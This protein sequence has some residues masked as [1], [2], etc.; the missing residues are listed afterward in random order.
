M[1]LIE[2]EGTS[3]WRTMGKPFKLTKDYVR[4]GTVS[5]LPLYRMQTKKYA[6]YHAVDNEGLHRYMAYFQRITLEGLEG[7]AQVAVQRDPKIK[8]KDLPVKVVYLHALPDLQIIFSDQKQTESGQWLWENKII[9]ACLATQKFV[10]TYDAATSALC[11][12][13]RHKHYA[14]DLWSERPGNENRIVVSNRRIDL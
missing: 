14:V 3:K 6:M 12:V 2:K 9:P 8:R 10:Y 13:T 7:W 1:R 11:R 5:K 4:V